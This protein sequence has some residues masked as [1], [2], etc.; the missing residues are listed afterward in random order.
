[1]KIWQV[2]RNRVGR[3]NLGGG[4]AAD[5]ST[6]PAFISQ[7]VEESTVGKCK[8]VPFWI[9]STGQVFQ[10]S[11]RHYV[12]GLDISLQKPRADTCK[13]QRMIPR[14][15][16][17]SIPVP[18]APASPPLPW[19]RDAHSSLSPSP[20][21]EQ[22]CF[23]AV[24]RSLPVPGSQLLRVPSSAALSTEA[25][26]VLRT[27]SLPRAVSHPGTALPKNSLAPRITCLLCQ[28][29]VLKINPPKIR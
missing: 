11:C 6:T 14:T 4:F 22:L 3:G 20:C 7:Q 19:R 10:V 12:S 15:S 28:W 29:Q 18:A 16:P 27:C 23:P 9:S 25:A 24:P 13:S 21:P 17:V 2:Q 5:G 1:M 26:F 8:L